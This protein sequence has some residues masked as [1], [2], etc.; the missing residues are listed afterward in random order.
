MIFEYLTL[1]K[2]HPQTFNSNAKHTTLGC[3]E[4]LVIL[5]QIGW[6]K[7]GIAGISN[8]FSFQQEFEAQENFCKDDSS[9]AF[10]TAKEP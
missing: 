3:K 1:D 2:N 5:R 9:C 4:R 7:G 8:L 6:W 10:K